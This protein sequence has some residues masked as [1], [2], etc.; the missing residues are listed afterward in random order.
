MQEIMH[1]ERAE[2]DKIICSGKDLILFFYKKNDPASIL[3]IHTMNEL[4]ALIGKSF[5]LYLINVDD[6][7]EI[8]KAF[9]VS[10]IPEYISV[11][12]SKIYKRCTDLLLSNEALLLLK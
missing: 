6:E 5:H 12:D 4:N 10:T 1:L 8:V 2:F 11:K 7:P 9:S 3:G